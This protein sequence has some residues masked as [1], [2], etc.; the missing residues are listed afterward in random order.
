MIL[1]VM[2]P[3]TNIDGESVAGNLKQLVDYLFR[4]L[5]LE[6]VGNDGVKSPGALTDVLSIRQFRFSNVVNTRRSVK[7]NAQLRY[8][9]HFDCR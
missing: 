6:G 7:T 1:Y 4:N 2:C 5:V 3:Y 9:S 8:G